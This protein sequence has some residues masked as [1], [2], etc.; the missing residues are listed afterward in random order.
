MN[1]ARPWYYQY[2]TEFGWFQT[3]SPKHPMRSKRIDLYFFS[4]FCENAYGKGTWPKSN[5]KN[6][7]YGALNLKATN[8]IFSNGIEGNLI[9][10]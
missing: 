10:K 5:R 9:L 7:E 4:R 3:F 2:C 1:A 6:N 8:I